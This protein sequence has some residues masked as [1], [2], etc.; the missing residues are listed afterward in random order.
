MA[1]AKIIND[2]LDMSRLSTGKLKL[3]CEDVDLGVLVQATVD[4]MGAPPGSPAIALQIERNASLHVHADVV[5]LEQVVWNLL[6]NAIK[7][8]PADG[9]I[10]VSISADQER[11]HL[12]VRDTGQG[13]RGDVLPVVFDMFEQGT[14]R[15]MNGTAGLGIGLALVRELV[16]LHGGQIKAESP[17]PGKGATFTVSLPYASPNA[18]DALQQ[19][20]QASALHGLRILLI[21]DNEDVLTLFTMLLESEGANVTTSQSAPGALDLLAKGDFDLVISDLTMPDMDGYEF[22]RAMREQ[23]NSRLVPALAVSGI[24]RSQDIDRAIQ[25]GFSAH[26]SKPVDIEVLAEVVGKLVSRT[27]E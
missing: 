5:R 18:R 12:S 1:Q 21:D 14:A 16:E 4:A 2:L 15:A 22:I 8:T 3:S 20:M 17:G 10:S 11:V 26:V 7:F 23:E 24:S 25:A 6:N 27:H 13:I 19:Q 9:A